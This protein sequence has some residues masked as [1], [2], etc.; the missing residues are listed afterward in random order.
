MAAKPSSPLTISGGTLSDFA[1]ALTSSGARLESATHSALDLLNMSGHAGAAG[2]TA[3]D[4][5]VA[6]AMHVHLVREFSVRVRTAECTCAYHTCASSSFGAYSQAA[7]TQGDTPCA[8]SVTPCEPDHAALARAHRLL[9]I[10]GSLEDALK[11]K[12]LAIAI[13]RVARKPHYMPAPAGRPWTPPAQRQPASTY[14]DLKRQAANDR[15]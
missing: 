2:D 12:S 3:D 13:R 4:L 14:P 5:R 11:D 10:Q 6:L 1:T 15:D 7:D 9:A 8:I